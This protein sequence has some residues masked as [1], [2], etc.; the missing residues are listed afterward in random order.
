MKLLCARRN[1]IYC[2]VFDLKED[3]DELYPHVGSSV[4]SASNTVC[5]TEDLCIDYDVRG[6]VSCVCTCGCI[7]GLER[8]FSREIVSVV[9][10]IPVRMWTKT[11]LVLGTQRSAHFSCFP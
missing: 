5:V 11:I 7:K 8:Y 6:C 10:S 9:W 2:L 4:C 3:N 1:T